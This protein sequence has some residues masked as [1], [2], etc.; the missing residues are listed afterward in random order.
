MLINNA[1]IAGPTA[2]VED[3]DPED[4]DRT[5][6]INISGQFYCARRAVPMLR[7]AGGGSIVNLASVAGLVGWPMLSLYCA[8]K[9]AV[10]QISRSLAQELRPA[11]IRVNALCPSVIGSD[12]G[13]RFIGA[14]EQDHG[15]PM[16]EV[17]EGRQGRI[18][19]VEEVA[20]AA[21]FLASPGASF[22]SGTAMAL[23]N[24]L[25]AG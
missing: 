11:G 8:S 16:R 22:I 6:A 14:Y 20:E 18:G 10:V 12:M 13:E 7:A 2:R 9:G 15:L 4:W 17:L 5:L 21:L 24:G 3:I 19:T 25:S 1:G 23:D